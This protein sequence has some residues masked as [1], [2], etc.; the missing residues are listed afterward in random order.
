M[1]LCQ[2]CLVKI[3][4]KDED[5]GTYK[6]YFCSK[7]CEIETEEA[8][9]KVMDL[10]NQYLYNQYWERQHELQ[11]GSKKTKKIKVSKKAVR[12]L[13]KRIMLIKSTKQIGT[14]R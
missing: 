12:Q 10:K 1:R 5:A 4:P 2:N 7:A 8:K 9:E 14:L 3:F 6:E 11:Q 13:V